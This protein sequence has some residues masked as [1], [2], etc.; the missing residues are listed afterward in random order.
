MLFKFE[1]AGIT[2]EF[3]KNNKGEVQYN[4]FILKQAGGKYLYQKE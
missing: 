2:I 1:R 3:S 4:S